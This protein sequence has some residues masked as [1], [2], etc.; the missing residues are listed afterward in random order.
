MMEE[1]SYKVGKNNIKIK[2]LKEI[3]F[4]NKKKIIDTIVESVDYIEGLGYLGFEEKEIGE[5]KEFLNDVIFST[6]NKPG[7]SCEIEIEKYLSVIKETLENLKEFFFEKD[8]YIYLVPSYDKFL[9]EKMDGIGG[10][11][12]NQIILLTIN[13]QTNISSKIISQSI[14]HE[15][16]NMVSLEVKEWENI[17]DQII[18]DGLA[19]QF[20]ERFFCFERNPWTKAISYSQTIELYESIKDKLL[21]NDEELSQDLFYGTGDYPLWTGY[22]LGYYIIE[23]FFKKNPD[24]SWKKVLYMTSEEIIE[25]TRFR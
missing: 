21:T 10:Y 7:T 14:V 25:E 18:S 6:E 3:H 1:I 20:S 19:E 9:I 4:D 24:I 23:D 12:S 17:L 22:T 16:I 13:P 2:Y 15:F 11:P 8:F 5:L